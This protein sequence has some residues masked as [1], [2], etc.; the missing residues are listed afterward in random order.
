MA[1]TSNIARELGAVQHRNHAPREPASPVSAGSPSSVEV[2]QQVVGGAFD[3]LV[4]PLRRAVE[5]R[6][7]A[8]A[9]EAGEVTEHE[10][11]AR[12]RLVGRT[13]GEGEVPGGVLV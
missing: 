2:L 4:L 9:V 13:V 12:L 8:H 11:V 1:S 10:G 6:D 3:L 5:A 7:H